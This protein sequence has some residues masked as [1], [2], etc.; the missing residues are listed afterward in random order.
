MVDTGNAMKQS[1]NPDDPSGRWVI[2]AFNAMGVQAVNV[3]EP[4]LRR[5]E[6][7][8][9]QRRLPAELRSDYLASGL[10]SSSSLQ[11]P[12]KRYSILNLKSASGAQEVR[13]GILGVSSPSAAKDAIPL[14][15][16][17]EALKRVIPELQ[18]KVDLIVL[19]TRLQD[20]EL[21]SLTQAFPSIG[22]IINGSAVGEGRD[23]QRIG[24]AV[25]VE[26]SHTGISLGVLEVEWDSAGRVTK[27]KNMVEPLLPMVQDSPALVEIV[28]KARRDSSAFQEEE[29]RKSPPVTVPS[30][31]AG[32]EVCKPC[33]EKAY[34][35]W[36][37]SHHANAI[38]TLVRS[39]AQY[40]QECLPCHVTGF[41]V[42]RGFV[43]VLRT[44]KLTGVQCEAC[45][46]ASVDHARDPQVVHPGVG[47]LQ[48]MR[49]TVRKEFC[50]RCH[51][52]ENSPRFN[53][54]QY[55]PKIAH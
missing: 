19:M 55:W 22:V 21:A 10:D 45:H 4:D 6:R 17:A 39:G 34:N 3:N 48:R 15:S 29:A 31:F 49:R 46:G 18:G 53:H 1:E 36:R 2:E 35:A 25:G 50:L 33:H 26:S 27:S 47:M 40:S 52:P 24:N 30:I 13:V 42:D 38:D 5:L 43:N 37:N 54:E 20:A 44:P 7:L 32:A 12:A 14:L 41:G 11:F 23:L 51:R 28:N 9:Q 16:P 8:K